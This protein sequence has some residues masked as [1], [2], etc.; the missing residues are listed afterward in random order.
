MDGKLQPELMSEIINL[1][2]EASKKIFEAQKKALKE[3]V[4][5]K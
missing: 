1:A 2:N 3:V 4:E 5:E